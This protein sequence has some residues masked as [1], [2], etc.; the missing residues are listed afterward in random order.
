ML[1][2]STMIAISRKTDHPSSWQSETKTRKY[3]NRSFSAWTLKNNLKLGRVR[4][5]LQWCSLRR[6]GTTRHWTYSL[7][8]IQHQSTKKTTVK[9]LSSCMC[10][11][12]TLLT[13]NWPRDLLMPTTLMLIMSTNMATHS[14]SNL[15][16]LKKSTLSTS[17]L[18][19]MCS[20]ISQMQMAKTHA[21]T[22]K[23]TGWL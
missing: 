14:C 22:L 8:S 5:L 18:V 19:E 4:V 10:S 23:K 2:L 11:K 7:S 1:I 3:S 21:I 12:R 13:G 16:N 17:W 9:R 6:T 15:C 20:F